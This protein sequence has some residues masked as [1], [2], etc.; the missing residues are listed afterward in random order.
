V[1]GTISDARLK[2]NIVDAPDYFDRLRQIRIVNY[3]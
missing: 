1:Y 2:E 3:N